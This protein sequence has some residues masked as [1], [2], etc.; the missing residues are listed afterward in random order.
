MSKIFV[1]YGGKSQTCFRAGNTAELAERK[2]GRRGPVFVVHPRFSTSWVE[3][4]IPK[5]FITSRL[6]TKV[7]IY[8]L[9]LWKIYIPTMG[10]FDFIDG[11][12]EF[13]IFW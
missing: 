12:S 13:S 9:G 1:E 7:L 4:Y 11:S 10:C 2:M 3:N 5:V 8:I 6:T